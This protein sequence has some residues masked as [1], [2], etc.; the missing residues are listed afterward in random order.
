MDALE[1]AR[2]EHVEAV[3]VDV[4]VDCWYRMARYPDPEMARPALENVARDMRKRLDKPL[5]SP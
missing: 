2:I 3:I 5:V 1:R 4:L